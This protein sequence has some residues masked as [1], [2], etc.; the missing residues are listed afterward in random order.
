[1]NLIWDK[2]R[3]KRERDR[4]EAMLSEYGS[5]ST[6]ILDLGSGNSPY[7]KFFPNAIR[8]DFEKDLTTTV[9]ADAQ[10]LP[11]KNNSFNLI[12]CTE[13]LEH[14]ENPAKAAAEMKRIL[15]IGGRLILTTRFIFP[16]HNSPHDFFRFTKYGLRN[17]FSSWRIDTIRED[18][19][20]LETIGIIFQRLAFQTETR[21]KELR[22]LFYLFSFIFLRLP[23]FIVASFAEVDRK[24]SE[25]A[26]L[27]SGYFLICRR[28]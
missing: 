10:N 15:K 20:E 16:I 11:F 28:V 8:V 27:S 17:I 1:M 25:H 19:T 18:T 21:P 3:S 22:F 26:L 5:N 14:L 7:Q 6:K 4:L 24:N 2:V 23:N 13:V 9:I 12:I